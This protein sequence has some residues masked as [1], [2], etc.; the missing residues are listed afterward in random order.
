MKVLITGA[1]GQLGQALLRL[2]SELSDIEVFPFAS[3]ELDI[4]NEAMVE[5]TL[6]R[7]HPDVL[8][9]CAAHTAVDACETDAENAYRINALGP[10]YLARA[11]QAVD[12]AMVQVST[13]YVFDGT[14]TTPYIESDLPNPQSVYGS[15]KLA[16]EE[17]AAKYLDRLYIVRSAWLYGEGHNFVRTMLR[18]AAEGKPLKVVNDQYGTPTAHLELARMILFLIQ[19]E[20]YG[21]YHATCEGF[22]TWYNFAREIFALTNT[23]VSLSPVATNGFK[24]A[25]KRPAYS[26]LENHKLNTETVY[27][28]ADWHDALLEY[29]KEENLL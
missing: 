18:L 19:T 7:L 15:T 4:T 1:K 5:A 17:Q 25:A 27:R 21:I 26:V 14:K 9:N 22:T 28:M 3:K 16:G 11:C 24:T 6:T 12:A 8:I 2:S 20:N 10:K 23:Q 29:L 13:D